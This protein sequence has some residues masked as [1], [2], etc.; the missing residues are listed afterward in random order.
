MAA[1]GVRQDIEPTAFIKDEDLGVRKAEELGGKESHERRLAVS[2]LPKNEAVG[3]ISDMEMKPK[4]CG[5]GGL[6]KADR[7]AVRW[8][9]WRG[10]LFKACPDTG[11]RDQIGDVSRMHQ[12][13]PDVFVAITRLTTQ[14]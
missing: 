3:H 14:E 11:T 2:C 8:H 4:R 13:A 7:R 10:V 9:Q 12:C 6:P 1:G 5:S